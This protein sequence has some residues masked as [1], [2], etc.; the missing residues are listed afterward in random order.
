LAK[1]LS[2]SLGSGGGKG[3]VIVLAGIGTAKGGAPSAAA[4]RLSSAWKAA[5]EKTGAQCAV[6][7][8]V[9]SPVMLEAF[10][11]A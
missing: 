7:V 11:D 1:R 6:S 10:E 2:A 4:N 5:C 9:E 8:E 3:D